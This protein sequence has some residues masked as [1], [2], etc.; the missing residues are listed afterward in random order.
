MAGN[1]LKEAKVIGEIL[2]KKKAYEEAI[3]ENKCLE[4]VKQIHLE[5]KR[6]T[7]ELKDLITEKDS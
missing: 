6:L 3:K 1:N 5:I 7:K 4:E 2:L